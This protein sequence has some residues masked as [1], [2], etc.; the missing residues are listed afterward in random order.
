MPGERLIQ[1]D[2]AQYHRR[3]YRVHPPE[4]E[5]R[6]RSNRARAAFQSCVGD[7]RPLPGAVAR[8]FVP[9]LHRAE[10]QCENQG[11]VQACRTRPHGDDYRPA[12][13]AGGATAIIRGSVL[14]HGPAHVHRE[15]LQEGEGSEPGGVAER[16]QGGQQGV[17]P[18]SR[19]RRGDEKGAGRVV[20]VVQLICM[21]A[22]LF[23]A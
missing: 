2:G 13:A 4:N 8:W 7:S 16:P 12:H 1:N 21:V 6:S 14:A 18:L 5:R 3:C 20:G 10:I 17:C 11:G 9:V 15:Y 22:M 23:V 19:H